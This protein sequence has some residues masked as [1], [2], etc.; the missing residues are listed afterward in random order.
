MSKI[1]LLLGGGQQSTNSIRL[2]LV[3][4]RKEARCCLLATYILISNPN[5]FLFQNLGSYD[6]NVPRRVKSAW[7]VIILFVVQNWIL[8]DS[9]QQLETEFYNEPRKQE[10]RKNKY[11]GNRKRKAVRSVPMALILMKGT[12]KQRN[13]R[14]LF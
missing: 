8:S 5:I 10:Q 1:K 7:N 11:K 12:I 6:S 9:T 2:F 4:C 13:G 3:K 14:Q